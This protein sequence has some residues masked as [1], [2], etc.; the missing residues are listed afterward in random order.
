MSEFPDAVK[1]MN[2]LT[3]MFQRDHRTGLVKYTAKL[4]DLRYFDPSPQSDRW[5][6]WVSF[7]YLLFPKIQY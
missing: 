2:R 6:Q 7:L 3:M 5:R 4:R 1:E